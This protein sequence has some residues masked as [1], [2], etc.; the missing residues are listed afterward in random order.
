MLDL[1]FIKQ[2][3]EVWTVYGLFIFIMIFTIRKWIPFLIENFKTLNASFLKA[4]KDQQDMFEKTLNNISDD[5]VK[6]VEA[7]EK[8]HEKHSNQLDE[9]KIILKSKTK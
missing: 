7:S 8:W 2:I 5:F 9:I 3:V 1:N 4:L 6:R